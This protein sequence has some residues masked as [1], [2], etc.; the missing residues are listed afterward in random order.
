[1][2]KFKVLILGEN[3]MAGH[4]IKDYLLKHT[5]YDLYGINEEYFWSRNEEYIKKILE[6]KPEIVINSLRVTVE[7][8][9]NDPKSAIY[10]NSVIPKMLEKLF[11]FSKTKI[12][13]LSTDCVFSG[14][15]GSY[16]EIDIPDGETVYSMTKFSGE[17]VNNKDITI[18]TSYIGPCLR[19]KNEELFDWFL[20]QNKRING[21]KNAIWNGVTT[22][23]LARII[24]K[25]IIND[26]SGIYHI[27]GNEKITKYDL[28]TII[29]KQ[30]GKKTTI[31]KTD[32]ENINRSLVDNNKYFSISNYEFMFNE[33]YNYMID[34]RKIYSHYIF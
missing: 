7:E 1:M 6:I 27:C 31:R 19:N 30:W 5:N 11:L 15:K 22:L 13:H 18:R 14:R 17:I 26:Y 32:G 34:R 25:I 33:L 24:N 8:S 16:V 29:K 3:G 28:L 23:E 2:K 20:N 10:I 4:L 12:I 9:Q 21:Y